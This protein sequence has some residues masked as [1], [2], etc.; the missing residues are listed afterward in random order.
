MGRYSN[1]TGVS[2]GNRLARSSVILRAPEESPESARAKAAA[3]VTALRQPDR[4]TCTLCRSL[5]IS[6]VCFAHCLGGVVNS[7]L[8]ALARLLRVLDGMPPRRQMEQG[9]FRGAG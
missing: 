2:S 8:L 4:R 9:R 6:E 3:H 5:R 1:C 7:G